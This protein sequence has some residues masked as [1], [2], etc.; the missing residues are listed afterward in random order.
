MKTTIDIDEA[1]LTR[2]MKLSGLKTRKAA[3]DYALRE[4]ER[5]A[6]VDCLVRDALPGDAYLDAVDPGYSVEKVRESELGSPS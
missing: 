1:R 6:R 4:A 5:V 2:V 3:V